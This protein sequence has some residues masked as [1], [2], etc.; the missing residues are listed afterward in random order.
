MDGGL[1]MGM[2]VVRFGMER[3]LG[4]VGEAVEGVLQT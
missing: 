2:G 1:E 4:F 3:M